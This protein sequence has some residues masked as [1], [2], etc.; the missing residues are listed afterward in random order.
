MKLYTNLTI[1]SILPHPS[2]PGKYYSTFCLWM[3][4]FYSI[5]ISYKWNHTIFVLLSL[6][7]FTQYTVHPY[8]D[9][10]YFV[11]LF[12]CQWTFRLFLPFDYFKQSCYN[13]WCE[14]I[15]LSPCF[16]FFGY[17]PTGRIAGSCGNSMFN[18]F[19]R[20]ATLFTWWPYHFTFPPSV[21][22]CSNISTSLTTLIFFF[23]SSFLY[24]S[25]H[26]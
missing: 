21:H 25:L 24:R 20:T 8:Y 17:V 9:I 2:A 18:F 14:N 6:T 7:H 26:P 13:N 15:S 11:Y 12:L 3:C 19:W 5:Y 16:Q 22:K 4:L 10:L 1:T 23:V